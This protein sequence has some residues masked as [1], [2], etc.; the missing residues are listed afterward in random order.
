MPDP[1]RAAVYSAEDQ[2]SALLNRGGRVDFHGSAL[3]VREQL[4]FGDLAAMQAYADRVLGLHAVA[5]RWPRCGAVTVR[6]RRGVTKAHYEPEEAVIAIPLTVGWAARESVLLH[7]LAHHVSFDA[8]HPH[9]P[10][11]TAAMCFL[12]AEAISPEAAL[13]LRAGYDSA[14]VA[15]A[16]GPSV[17]AS[18]AS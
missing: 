10:G 15:V 16:A 7:E 3:F 8:S 5:L 4:R 14:G 6:T 2:W 1:G 11:F 9:G 13:L 12:A 17:S 18:D